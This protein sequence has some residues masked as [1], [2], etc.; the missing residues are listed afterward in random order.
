[1]AGEKK[2][3]S[4][5]DFLNQ[6][7]KAAVGVVAAGIVASSTFLDAAALHRADVKLRFGLV[8]YQWGRAWDL[9]TLLRNCQKAKALGVELRTE[10]AHGVDPHLSARQRYEVKLRFENSPVELL[11]L[12]TNWAF[13]SPDPNRLRKEIQGA[14]AAIKL[15]HDVG[16]SGVKVKPN[17]LP[18]EVP[19][20]QTIEQIG[21]TLNELGRFGADY[22]QQIRVEVHG[23]NTQQLPVMKQIFDVADHPNVTVCWNSNGQ[24]LDG[25]GLRY[26]FDL[27]KDRFG[28]TAHVREFDVGDYPYQDLINL[29]VEMRYGGWLLMEARTEPMDRVVALAAQRA[30][31][32]QMVAKAQH[33]VKTG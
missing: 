12:G 15:S 2:D 25:Q 24:D 13:H 30:L 10:H 18:D 5:R 3:L 27:V 8:T 20:A 31:F 23:R 6:G 16:G 14:R 21:T 32:D 28:K 19:A 7:S 1:M 17:G 29:F 22:G 26:N 9:P 4:R 11:G 33:S